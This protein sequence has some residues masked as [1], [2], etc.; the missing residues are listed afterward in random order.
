MLVHGEDPDPL[1]LRLPEIPFGM[2]WH[3]TQ[4]N[5]NEKSMTNL[6]VAVHMSPDSVFSDY[7]I[8]WK[9]LES[10]I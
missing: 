1:L 4:T 9:T 5:R 8:K 6:T 10:L 2:P 3:S 7:N